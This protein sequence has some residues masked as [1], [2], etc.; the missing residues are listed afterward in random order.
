MGFSDF[1]SLIFAL[2]ILYSPVWLRW[3]TGEKS[4][5]EDIV[6][7]AP[8]LGIF[9]TFLG[10]LVA[11]F[12]FK[13]DEPVKMIYG[14]RFAFLTSIA[15]IL[16]SLWARRRLIKSR[17]E[18]KD[19]TEE[20]LNNIYKVMVEINNQNKNLN[21][22]ITGLRTEIKDLSNW[23]KDYNIE[24]IINKY[25]DLFE[26][27]IQ[28]IEKIELMIKSLGDVMPSVSESIKDMK[29]SLERISELDMIF[30]NITERVDALSKS[31]NESISRIDKLLASFEPIVSNLNSG[32]VELVREA[33]NLSGNI[34][35]SIGKMN[36]D[37]ENSLSNLSKRLSDL[38]DNYVSE[39]KNFYERN[40]AIIDEMDSSL[41]KSLFCL[42]QSLGALIEHYNT[43]IEKMLK[44]Y[45]GIIEKMLEEYKEISEL[46]K[47]VLSSL[48]E[49]MSSKRNRK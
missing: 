46:L 27:F 24:V 10:I 37:I 7:I 31:L 6:V 29:D 21:E 14:I 35:I 49:K 41:E 13:E 15:G 16:I 12:S 39:I 45:K 33:K 34:N 11:L 28:S 30:E 2:I 38:I 43:E 9:G 25:K 19:P 20:V 1:L 3:I 18:S 47:D 5:D 17:V 4:H 44:D 32:F 22:G 23:L 26:S 36:D 8:T 40:K 42:Q 48:N